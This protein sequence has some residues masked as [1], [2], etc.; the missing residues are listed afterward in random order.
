MYNIAYKQQN[1]FLL[2]LGAEKSKI[3]VQDHG[4]VLVRV[5]SCFIA[6][7][8]LLCSHLVEGARELSRASFIKN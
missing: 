4:H 2:V 6:G 8:F 1:L 5:L 7:V 3:G